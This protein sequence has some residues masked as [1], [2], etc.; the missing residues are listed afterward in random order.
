[1]AWYAAEV[2][3]YSSRQKLKKLSS[4]TALSGIHKLEGLEP[5]FAE[6]TACQISVVSYGYGL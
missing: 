3:K 5:T 6:M 1:M 4:P 2:E